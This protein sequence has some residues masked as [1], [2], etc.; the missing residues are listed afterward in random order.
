MSELIKKNDNCTAI[1]WKLLT[2]ASAL[3]L[4]AYISAEDVASAADTDRPIIWFEATGQFDQLSGSQPKWISDFASTSHGGPLSGNYSGYQRNPQIGFDA[5]LSASF[6]PRD[7]DW[8]LSVSVRIGRSRREDDGLKRANYLPVTHHG[9]Y[10]KLGGDYVSFYNGASHT[11]ER[12]LFID[13]LAG[14]DIGIGRADTVIRAGLRIAQMKVRSD[15]HVSSGFPYTYYGSAFNH[16]NNQISRRFQGIGPAIAW[17]GSVPV[18]GTT[19]D[20]QLAI[21][22]AANAAVLF[23]RQTTKQKVDG[24]YTQGFYKW[25]SYGYLGYRQTVR[26]SV[27]SNSVRRRNVTVPD[28]GGSIGVSYRLQN[29]KLTLGYRAEYLFNVLDGGV[30]ASQKIN[31]GFY[32]PFATISIGLG[33]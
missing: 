14:R 19:Q 22:W 20:G 12:H 25:S 1:R 10:E 17:D 24:H 9:S 3:A 31:R 4:V 28:I 16:A 18:A 2:G 5:G 32:G 29:T 6:Q 11:S 26:Q 13:F 30:A 8:L 23:G 7:S 15:L 21:D 27:A 33:G